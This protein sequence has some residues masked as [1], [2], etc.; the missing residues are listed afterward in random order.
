MRVTDDSFQLDPRIVARRFDR[1]ASGFDSVDFVHAHTRQSLFER[2]QPI[3]IKAK[4]VL[5]LGCATGTASRELSRHFKGS[6]LLSLDLS[7]QMLNAALQKR[8]VFRL[9]SAIN[10]DA[11]ALPFADN[12][13]DVV[14]SNL[15][16][17][18]AGKP[19]RVFAEVSR[20]LRQGGL[21]LFA[22][23]GPD[24]LSS[25]RQSWHELDS[26]V[27]VNRFDDMHDIGDGLVRAGLSDPVLDVDRLV[28]SYASTEALFNDLTAVGARNS[29][30]GR[31]RSLGGRQ[32]FDRMRAR[33]ENTAVDG[34]IN[35][36][37]EL[38]YGHCWGGS[39]GSRDNAFHVDAGSIPVRRRQTI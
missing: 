6:R 26:G 7:R 3:V 35:V 36:S 32:N 30:Q 29:L 27:H 10:A 28:V 38:V 31:H 25:L 39:A 11:T 37:L 12:S 9:Q 13:I 1:A 15:M 4:T 21:F 23:L 16:L 17:P 20:V 22:T 34:K 24:S 33:L 18:W 5:D 14:F 8:R 19:D 2:L